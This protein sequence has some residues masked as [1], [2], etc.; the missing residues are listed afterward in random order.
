MIQRDLFRRPSGR[1]YRDAGMAQVSEN[2]K[3]W[4]DDV[5]AAAEY[6]LRKRDTGSHNGFTSEILRVYLTEVRGL[7]EP[8]HHNAW[9]AVLGSL[10]RRWV[11]DRKIVCDGFVTSSNP[12]SHAR[13]IRLYHKV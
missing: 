12:S 1:V 13:A 10:L 5:R 2:A 9:S 8:H 7:P 3:D 11:K 6:W 4:A